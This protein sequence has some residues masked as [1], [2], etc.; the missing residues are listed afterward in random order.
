M[1]GTLRS[2]GDLFDGYG[3]SA[4]GLTEAAF[5]EMVAL[6]GSAREPYAAV[7]SSLAQMGPEDVSARGSR[8]ARAFMDQGVT[9]DLDGEERPF[10]LDVVPR[11]FTGA[12]WSKVAAGVAQRVRALELFLDDIY[13]AARIVSDGLIPHDVITSSPGFVRAAYG[14]SPSNG[15]RIHVAG[16]DVIRDEDGEFRVLEDNLRSPSGVSY[17]LANRAAM[18]RVLPELFWGQPIQMVTDYPARLI[19]ALRR[20]APAAVQDPTVVVL[21]PGVHNSAFYEHALLARLMGVHLVEGRDLVCHGTDVFL[22]TT[23]GEVP[24]HVIYRRIDDD[25]LDPLQ[26]RPESLVGC[27]GVINAARAGRVTIA[28]GVGNGVAD[29]KLVYTYV[30]AMIRYYLGEDPIL[31]NVETMHLVDNAVRKDA[32][33]AARG[34]GLQ[35]GRRLRRQGAGHRAFGDRCRTRR[36]GPRGGSRSQALDRPA[37]GRA[38]HVAHL[39]GQQHGAPA[40]R[41][42]TLCSQRRRGRLGAPWWPD[43][44]RPGRGQPGGELQPRR[45]LQG[46]LGGRRRALHARAPAAPGR[47]V[48]GRAADG[49]RAGIG[50]RAWR[51]TTTTAAA[52]VATGGGVMPVTRALLSRVAESIFWVGRYVERAEGTARILDVSV[53]QA[54]EQSDVEGSHA[55]RRLLAVMGLPDSGTETLWQ[56]TERL[57]TDSTSRSSIAGALAAA[58]ENT[59]AVRHVV[60]VEFWEHIN[61]TWAELPLRWETGRRAGPAFYLS[62]VKTQCAGMMGL[63]DTMMSRDQTWLFF[64]LGRCLERTD[65]VARQLATVAF[66]EVFDSGLV[67]LLRSCGGYEPYL[68]LSQ[69]VV[70]PGRVLDFLLRDR[71]FPRSAFASLTLAEECLDQINAGREGTWDD[72]RG[73]IGLARAELEYSAPATLSRGLETRLERLQASISSVSDAVT[74]RYF[75]QDLPMQWRQGGGGG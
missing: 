47:T 54:L 71:L 2:V 36:A 58:R 65:V 62:F 28:N 20:S 55:A 63:A 61:A 75:A 8:L 52:A 22:R 16:I 29:D 12:E 70:E 9:F 11:I 43:T 19:N 24:V 25:Y 38:L 32:L 53:Y 34:P 59:R 27:P 6:D 30:P 68:R 5:D 56:A 67:M 33:S 74:R 35:A 14:F 4:R 21:T 72:A 15:V 1:P 42:A 41:P 18:A 50:W 37:C 60:P 51:P 23:E 40:R 45:W 3:S 49:R 66:D 10:P 73:L 7:A 31:H 39:G 44:G 13:G 46:H 64:T 26:F 17:V 48:P 69:G 57:A